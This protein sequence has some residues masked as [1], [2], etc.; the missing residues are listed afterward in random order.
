MKPEI[1]LKKGFRSGDLPPVIDR[2]FSFEDY[3]E[4]YAYMASKR[5]KHRKIILEV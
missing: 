2:T 1:L 4:A 3:R 5:E